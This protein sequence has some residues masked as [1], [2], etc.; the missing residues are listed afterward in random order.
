MK[1][2]SSKAKGINK[3]INFAKDMGIT[4]F[5]VEPTELNGAGALYIA[6][7]KI[8]IPQEQKKDELI[9]VLAHELGHAVSE[10]RGEVKDKQD[11]IYR[12]SYPNSKEEICLGDDAKVIR[13]IEARAIYHAE[14]I[15]KRL[16]IRIN[17][18]VI[19]KDSLY[20]MLALEQILI[21]GQISSEDTRRIWTVAGKLI[22]EKKTWKK[23]YKDYL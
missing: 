21:C 5:E 16:K 2:L 8:Y 19:E 3:L 10:R 9:L 13:Y 4:I 6:P 15:I 7:D 23:I 11:K 20:C 17:K 14:Q 18:T 22:S 1:E 12:N